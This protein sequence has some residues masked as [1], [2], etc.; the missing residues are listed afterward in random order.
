MFKNPVRNN[1]DAYRLWFEY[2]KANKDYERLCREIREYLSLQEKKQSFFIPSNDWQYKQLVNL[3]N[4]FSYWGDVYSILW[5]NKAADISRRIEQAKTNIIEQDKLFQ[6]YEPVGLEAMFMLANVTIPQNYISLA[7]PINVPIDD[8]IEQFKEI[9]F[10]KQ[11][12]IK[13]KS[14]EKK[15]P[16]PSL[17]RKLPERDLICLRRYLEVYRLKEI[18]GL[19]W[20]E[21]I[22]KVDSKDEI[23]KS[24]DPKV[25]RR[26]RDN[27]KDII[28]NTER[29]IFPG[30][31]GQ[32]RE[33]KKRTT[34][35][36]SR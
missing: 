6:L 7:I 31:Y 25:W 18:E 32:V 2:L 1:Q 4:V 21:V 13:T 3:I 8:L 22:Q 9:V 24:F 34:K 20:G 19:S 27:A 5:E 17:S 14:V 16:F 11:E 10:K 30:E 29:N 23:H 36:R 15:P 33:R 12:E 26:E 28:K 35:K